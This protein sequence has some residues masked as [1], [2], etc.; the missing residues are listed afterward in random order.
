MTTKDGGPAFPTSV[1]TDVAGNV[2]YPEY[3]MSLRD[4]FAAKVMQSN[5]AVIR[6]FPDETWRDGLARD[7][8]LMADAMLK[9][10]ESQ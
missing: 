1:Y 7:S 8:Y 3:G 2:W 10:R 4:Y 5:L 9:V 6:E